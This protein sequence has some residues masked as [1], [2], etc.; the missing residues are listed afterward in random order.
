M[1]PSQVKNATMVVFILLVSAVP[2]FSQSASFRSMVEE[3]KLGNVDAQNDLGIAYSEGK[4]VKPTQRKAVY[5]F[6]K[7]AEQGYAIGACNLALHYGRGWGVKRSIT[8]M[9]K[10]VFVAHALDGLKCNP[11]AVDPRH[12]QRQCAVE[13]GWDLAVA[14]LRTRPEFKNRFGDQPWMKE[15]GVY[16]VTLRERVDSVKL[17]IEGSRGCRKK[18]GVR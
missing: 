16:P 17:P 9:W 13:R 18:R 14:W 11:A 5:W 4:G 1:R 8:L 6:R 12:W 2:V 15:N 10:Y 3:A 7:S